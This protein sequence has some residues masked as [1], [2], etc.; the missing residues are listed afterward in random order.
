MAT[1]STIRVAKLLGI[2]SGTFH[3]WIREKRVQ[4]PPLQSVLGMNVRAWTE[5]D[6][7]KVR[8]YKLEHYWGKGG[9]KKRKK[10]GK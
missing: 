4:A 8:K 3:R 5:E 1:F 2:A 6:I 9:R 10:R 7:Q